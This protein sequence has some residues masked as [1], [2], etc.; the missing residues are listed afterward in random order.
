[1]GWVSHERGDRLLQNEVLIQWLLAAIQPGLTST[2]LRTPKIIIR[3]RLD[4]VVDPLVGP[5]ERANAA[6]AVW[7]IV[8]HGELGGHTATAHAIEQL[9]EGQ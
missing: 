7:F 4:D 6:P 5:K 1:M 3:S 8:H 2:S 9:D